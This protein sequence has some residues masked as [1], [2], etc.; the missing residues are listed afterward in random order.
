[1]TSAFQY[2][3]A[4]FVLKKLSPR[5]RFSGQHGQLMTK[6]SSVLFQPPPHFFHENLTL[7]GVFTL[8]KANQ[9]ELKT[10]TYDASARKRGVCQLTGD[11]TP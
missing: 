10:L 9:N 3:V 6:G 1:M 8:R 7:F 2:E 4:M 11:E 5:W